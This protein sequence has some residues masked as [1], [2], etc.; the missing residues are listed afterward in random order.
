[1]A[2]I[3]AAEV[4]NL[5]F[6]NTSTNVG[7]VKDSFIARAE[8]DF[9]KTRLGEDLYNVIATSPSTLDG[10]NLILYSTYLKPSMAYF[11]KYLMLPDLHMNTTSSG[12]QINNREFSATAQSKERA[13]LANSTLSMANSFLENGI[14]YIE[15]EDNID[16]FTTYRTSEETKPNSKIIGGIVFE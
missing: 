3:T 2:L 5:S 12:I 1:M 9:I 10:K 7:L 4:I 15:H 13:E 16:Y 11:V 8:L 6:T 14:K